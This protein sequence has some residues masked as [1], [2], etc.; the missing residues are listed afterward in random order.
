M[1]Y[2]PP[3]G[4]KGKRLSAVL[5]AVACVGLVGAAVLDVPYRIF[6]QLIAFAVYIFSFELLNRYY[7]ATF[8]Y[9]VTD[10]DFVITKRTGKRV[11]TVCC[12][13]LSTLIAVEPRPRTREEK[14]ALRSAYGAHPLRYN[15]CQSLAPRTAY[16]AFFEFNGRTARIDF[17]G[18]EQMAQYLRQY[19]CAK[20]ESDE[21]TY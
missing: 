16:C 20:K 8:C 11:Q 21:S 10:S 7:L 5:L 3:K 18:S 9:R 17:E 12:L 6:Y 4:K 1:E 2:I 19:V 15:Y 14:D 13:A